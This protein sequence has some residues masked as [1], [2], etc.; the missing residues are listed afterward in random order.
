MERK[1]KFNVGYV[2]FELVA[3]ERRGR[4]SL[5]HEILRKADLPAPRSRVV[6]VAL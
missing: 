3:M 1:T 6:S 4:L 2:L 5:E